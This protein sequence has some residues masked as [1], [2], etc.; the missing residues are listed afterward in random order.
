MLD[1]EAGIVRVSAL[2]RV[3]YEAKA[4]DRGGEEVLA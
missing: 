4:K 3:N 2:A 1:D